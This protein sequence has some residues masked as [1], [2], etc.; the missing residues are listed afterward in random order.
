MSIYFICYDLVTGEIISQK[1]VAYEEE[2]VMNTPEGQGIVLGEW[3]WQTHYVDIELSVPVLKPTVPEMTEASYDLSLLPA[4]ASL[5]VTDP[6][7]METP[8][9]AQEDTLELMDPGEW[10]VRVID[11]PFPWIGF[12]TVV[13]VSEP[14]PVEEPLGEET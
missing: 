3:D 10:K 14:E 4:G 7:G 6:V 5:V 2:I 13:V 12:E 8:I 1:G 11:L 9:P